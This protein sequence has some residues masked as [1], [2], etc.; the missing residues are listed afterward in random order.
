MH[1]F[2]E[3]EAAQ[4]AKDERVS[5]PN[6]VSTRVA[7]VNDRFIGV[8]LQVGDSFRLRLDR[9]HVHRDH[10]AFSRGLGPKAPT[11][12]SGREVSPDPNRTHL[13]GDLELRGSLIGPQ[14]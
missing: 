4:P 10:G 11:P 1:G 8:V 6:A 5:Y 14:E 9:C 7:H 3:R 12:A 13:G 2:G